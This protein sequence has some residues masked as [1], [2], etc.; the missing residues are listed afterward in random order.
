[1]LREQPGD[2]IP[3]KAGIQVLQGLLDPGFRR[4][5]GS[6]MVTFF[7]GR[8]LRHGWIRI[9]E[10][11]MNTNGGRSQGEYLSRDVQIDNHKM[12]LFILNGPE[13]SLLFIFPCQ[14]RH[15]FITCILDLERLIQLPHLIGNSRQ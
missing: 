6:L 4:G 10:T 2:F 14:G 7:C 13:P 12:P 5:D 1:V 3:T 15:L 8:V 11:R 9:E